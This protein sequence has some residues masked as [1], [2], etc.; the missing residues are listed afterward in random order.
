M[1]KDIAFLP[2]KHASS[3]ASTSR[4]RLEDTLEDGDGNAGVV[5]Q[6]DGAGGEESG[7]TSRFLTCSADKTIKLWDARALRA[8]GATSE[9]GKVSNKALNTYVGRIGFKYVG[10][11]L[12]MELV[13]HE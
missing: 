5:T 4:R 3:E 13:S 8:E 11:Q 1:V 2:T 7:N 12:Q 9:R 10:R 6:D